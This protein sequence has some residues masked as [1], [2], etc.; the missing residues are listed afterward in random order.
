MK[1]VFI[2][3]NL[4]A[5]L[6]LSAPIFADTTITIN[7]KGLYPEGVSY[8]SQD[9][10]FYVSSVARGEVWKVDKQGD[11]ELFAKN[12]KFVSTIGLKVD[13]KQNRLLVCISDPGVGENTSIASKGRL[14]GLAV[15]DLT[16]KKEIAYYDLAHS[17]AFSNDKKGHLANDV[18]IDDKGNFYVTDSFSPIIYKIDSNGNISILVS[19]PKWEVASGKFGLNGISYH[20]DNFLIVAHYST[21]KLYKIDLS[22]PNDFKE[23][24]ILQASEKWKAKGLDG[25]LLLNNK[26]LI[27]VNND[28]SGRENGNFIMRLSSSDNW[29]TAKLSGVMPTN[30]TFPTTLTKRDDEVFV[31]HA[32]LGPLFM[33]NKI[34]EK[35]FEIEP[36]TFTEIK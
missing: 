13:E 2:I 31:L 36:L 20:P 6:M 18:T 3:A 16:T 26:T 25:L 8:N 17:L 5:G 7:N 21:G 29:K 34:P 33:G 4:M 11:S 27:A 19:S 28:L 12:R 23:I 15:Y 24:A 22:K 1:K 14:A 32:K 9:K 35:K 10:H 30:A